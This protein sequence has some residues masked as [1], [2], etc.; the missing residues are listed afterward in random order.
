MIGNFRKRIKT[1]R[2]WFG[3]LFETIERS[4]VLIDSKT[5]VD[6]VPKRHPRDIL[7][8]FKKGKMSQNSLHEFIEENFILPK[9]P[10]PPASLPH[11]SI[12]DALIYIEKM[13]DILTHEAD[14]NENFS[15]LLALPYE[16][17]MPGG[18]FREIYYWDSYF[19]MVG[20][21][22]SGRVALAREMLK[23][24]LSQI[25]LFGFIP[26]GNRTYYLSRSQPPTFSL[27]M[28]LLADAQ[29]EDIYDIYL[30]AAIREY[31]YWMRGKNNLFFK[32]RI[33]NRSE[34]VVRMPGGEILNRYFDEEP[35]PRE[36]SFAEDSS[37]EAPPRRKI[38]DLWRDMRAGAESGWDYSSRWF[39]DGKSRET[40]QTTSV[41]PVDL[42]CL[43]FMTEEI[44]ADAA[45]KV[46]RN[47]ISKKFRTL[48]EER[49]N[50]ILKYFYNE[51][52]RWFSDYLYSQK[53]ISPHL[54]LAGI[55]PLFAGIISKK[56]ARIIVRVLMK[57]FLTKGGLYASLKVT[58]EQWDAPNGWA[59]LHFVAII[60][61][62]KYGFSKE[63][64][65]IANRWLLLNLTAFKHTGSFL[66]KYNVENPDLF[67]SG[68]EYPVQDGFGWTNAVFLYLHNRYKKNPR[69]AGSQE[70]T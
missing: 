50:A 5:F 25:D 52:D 23:N 13:W 31:E 4:R 26:N 10:A 55:F 63:A 33:K 20:L 29:G 17:V 22:E 38:R 56:Q 12:D 15:S 43:L 47:A 9:N 62:E 64:E 14:S 21:I 57:K 53:K 42:N 69:K 59:P 27:M 61:L 7:R 44:I 35:E 11:A 46:G 19:T 6:A 66:E 58:G 41:V 34:H 18:R 70:S 65:E 24:F 60:G 28:K 3:K 67:A 32:R 40:I 30:S 8:D 48:A 16:Y 37:L 1:P 68:G 39:A 2:R 49:K 51:D 54:S 36:E 45:E